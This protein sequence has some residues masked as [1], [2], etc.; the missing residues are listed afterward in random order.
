MSFGQ[1]MISLQDM[2]Y[3][4]NLP[5]DGHAVSG[6]LSNFEQL[7]ERESQHEYDSKIY[8][9]MPP[10]AIEDTVW[11]YARGYIMT[12]LPMILFR[13]KSSARVHLRWDRFQPSSDEKGPRVITTCSELQLYFLFFSHKSLAKC[14]YT[15]FTSDAIGRLCVPFKTTL[16]HSIYLLSYDHIFNRHTNVGS[17]ILGQFYCINQSLPDPPASRYPHGLCYRAKSIF[18]QYMLK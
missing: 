16:R 18:F 12:L 15:D 13:D 5:I 6:C 1:C 9:V 17:T 14:P 7:I 8:L 4:F 2:A 10:N 3:Q 11:V